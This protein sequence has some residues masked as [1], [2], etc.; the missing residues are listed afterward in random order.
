L[1]HGLAGS[2]APELVERYRELYRR[3][4]YLPLDYREMLARRA[5]PL[6]AKHRLTADQRSFRAPRAV[7]EAPAVVQPTLF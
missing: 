4:A 5:D 6:V 2:V 3:G 1:V 7:S